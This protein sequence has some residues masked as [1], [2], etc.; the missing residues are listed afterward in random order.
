MNM[1]G[2]LVLTDDRAAT[3]A[4]FKHLPQ[5]IKKRAVIRRRRQFM[6]A[7]NLSGIVAVFVDVS[8]TLER[9]M[10]GQYWPDALDDVRQL[11]AETDSPIIVLSPLANEERAIEMYDAGADEYIVKPLIPSLATA[12]VLAWLRWTGNISDSETGI[13]RSRITS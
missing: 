1:A 11:R 12:K 13:H 6:E 7:C 10:A 2:I 4:W 9:S 8:K 5:H 3:P